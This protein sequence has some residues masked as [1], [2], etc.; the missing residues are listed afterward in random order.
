MLCALVA[1][2]VC[3]HQCIPRLC[4]SERVWWCVQCG[5]SWRHSCQHPRD[6]AVRCSQT[7]AI[8]GFHTLCHAETSRVTGKASCYVFFVFNA[9]TLNKSSTFHCQPF[10]K[11][12]SLL[13]VPSKLKKHT[14][15]WFC[16]ITVDRCYTFGTSSLTSVNF[17]SVRVSSI[18]KGQGC[19]DWVIS[20]HHDKFCEGP[21]KDY[22]KSDMC[23]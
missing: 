8:R 20:S 22:V 14:S 3:P 1:R 4:V 6:C 17:R 9:F 21:T 16:I 11:K 12:G 18:R 10:S 13:L 23:T 19:S 15:S 2:S 7:L 5:S